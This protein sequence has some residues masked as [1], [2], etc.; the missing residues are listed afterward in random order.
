MNASVCSWLAYVNLYATC[1]KTW[2]ARQSVACSETHPGVN[3]P[4]C[5]AASANAA[6]VATN[7]AVTASCVPAARF[8]Q[9]VTDR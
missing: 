6:V 3:L 2:H 7:A 5:P 9:D 8:L 1:Q 4:E